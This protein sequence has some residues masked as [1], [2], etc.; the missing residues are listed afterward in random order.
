M[1]TQNIY[2]SRKASAID[3]LKAELA[4]HIQALMTGN[5]PSRK[6][7]ATGLGEVTRESISTI[8]HGNFK[9]CSME[10]MFD[11]LLQLDNEIIIKVNPSPRP[12][13]G[14]FVSRNGKT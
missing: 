2:L 8:C 7:V 13:K 11:I 1:A 3:A 14:Q 4:A 6:K 9:D 10:E 5:R 12:K